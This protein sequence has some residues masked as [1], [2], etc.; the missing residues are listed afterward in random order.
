MVTVKNCCKLLVSNA[1]VY[2]L[3]AAIVAVAGFVLNEV[4]G[5]CIALPLF[6]VAFF[7]IGMNA[8]SYVIG[9][10]KELS[11]KEN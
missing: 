7:V 8:E 5:L 3:S 2:V 1:A 6:G 9:K 10:V 4:A 11:E